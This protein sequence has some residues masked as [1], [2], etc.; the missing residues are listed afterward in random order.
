MELDLTNTMLWISVLLGGIVC[1]GLSA[2]VQG[3]TKEDDS[4]T[5]NLKGVMRDGI[6]GGIFIAMAWTLIPDSMTT[7]TEKVSSTVSS[8]TI[9][10]SVPKTTDIELQIGPA[11]F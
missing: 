4:Q 3:Y 6:L 7:I 10:V 2:V 9:S 8:A 1:A 5:F 11:H